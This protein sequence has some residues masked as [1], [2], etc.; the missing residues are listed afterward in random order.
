MNTDSK[1]NKC[2]SEEDFPEESQLYQSGYKI[3]LTTA[4]WKPGLVKLQNPIGKGCWCF[5]VNFW[6]YSLAKFVAFQNFHLIN[7]LLSKLFIVF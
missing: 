3:I 7:F 2:V 5:L 1:Y 6:G 4:S